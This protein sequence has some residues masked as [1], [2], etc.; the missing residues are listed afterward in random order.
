MTLVSK[1]RAVYTRVTYYWKEETHCCD[2]LFLYSCSNSILK[3][4]ELGEFFQCLFRHFFHKLRYLKHNYQYTDQN[5]G[6]NIDINVKFMHTI[7]ENTIVY[8]SLHFNCVSM[9]TN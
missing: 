1:E 5:E 6:F 3:S 9:H 7:N 2:Y 8:S 4:I